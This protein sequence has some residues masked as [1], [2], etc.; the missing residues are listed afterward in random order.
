[1]PVKLGFGLQLFARKAFV[2][3]CGAIFKH[4]SSLRSI[5]RIWNT[6]D[7]K[8]TVSGWFWRLPTLG[9]RHAWNAQVYPEMEVMPTNP[10]KALSRYPDRP[11]H[12]RDRPLPHFR[13]AI[14]Y[15]LVTFR[16]RIELHGALKGPRPPAE[17]EEKDRTLAAQMPCAL[18]LLSM[19]GWLLCAPT[20]LGTCHGIDIIR[21]AMTELV[22]GRHFGS[23]AL[24]APGPACTVSTWQALDS[25]ADLTSAEVAEPSRATR[26][27]ARPWLQRLW[28]HHRRH[29]TWTRPTRTVC[30]CQGPLAPHRLKRHIEMGTPV[31]LS[32]GVRTMCR[33]NGW[34]R[35]QRCPRRRSHGGRH[36][37][38]P[39]D[40]LPRTHLG[41]RCHAVGYLYVRLSGVTMVISGVVS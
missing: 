2:A 1:M 14:R 8:C 10:A 38:R 3:L 22:V 20:Q 41:G 13:C 16:V 6:Q 12:K 32:P 36:G 33:H 17:T 31:L 18:S 4:L 21:H 25:T 29:V 27:L 7:C 19:L 9:M 39:P 23:R 26:A 30:G 5:R 40:A 35:L 28:L 34:P 15:D 24:W 11:S 37:D